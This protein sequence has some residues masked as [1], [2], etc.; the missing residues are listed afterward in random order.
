MKIRNNK[1]I[2]L[3]ALVITIVILIIL[4]GIS[5]QAITN[6]GLFENVKKAKEKSIEGQ[7]KEEISL[8]IQSIQTEEIYKGNSVTLETLAGGQL[9]KELKDITAELTDGEIN[10]EYKDYEYTID[11]NFNVT[12]N[13]PVTGVKITGDAE[14]Q[15]EG[16]VFE[17]NTVEIKVTASITEG[18]IT[19][20]EAPDGVTL[21]T[22][23][24]T[25][26][27]VYTANKNGKYVFKI[28]SDAGKTKNITAKVENILAAPQITVSEVTE[29]S[30]KINVENNYPEGAITEYRYSVG[31]TV[32]RQ[33]TTDKS[34]TVTG[35]AELT[36]YN[37]IQVTAYI[38]SVNKVSNVEKVTTDLKDGIAYSWDEIA[39]MAKAISNDSSI[40]DDSDTATVN[41]K[42][43]KVGQMK[44]LDGKR[45]RILGFNH[46]TLSE[47]NTAYGSRTATGKAGISFEYVDFLIS[48]AKMNSSDTNSGGWVNAALRGTLNGTTYNSLS[49]KNSI[50]KVKKEYIPTY[51][52]VPTTMPTTDDYLWL[53]SCGEI[54]DNGYNGG[55]TRGKAIATE[56]KQ[57][58]YYKMNLGSTNYNTSNNITKK[59]TMDAKD[60]KNVWI[61]RS[62]AYYTSECFCVVTDYGLC[63]ETRSKLPSQSCTRFFNLA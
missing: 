31:G 45:V 41:G 51:N 16:Y 35:L 47:P 56:G 14:V 8:A 1:A 11:S 48:S 15:T 5:I 32:K 7:L 13:G 2:T 34:Y 57:Y 42:T 18:T 43:L 20:I 44:V 55:I 63:G 60:R 37:N 17:G 26:E 23:T 10:G 39:E 50:K 27:K 9:E 4:A 36:E 58:K 22:D 33:G 38:N 40:T 49:I 46:N 54:W 29:N 61:L 53:L 6:T 62:P 59:P 12:I 30:F 19:G 25:T 21:K 3:V 52:T 28:T 24:N